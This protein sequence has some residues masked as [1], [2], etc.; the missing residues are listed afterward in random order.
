MLTSSL[1]LSLSFHYRPT[2]GLDPN[3][4]RFVWDYILEIKEKRIIILTTHSMEE[5]DALC[6]RIGI[7]VNGE[8]KSLGTPQEL[9]HMYGGGYRVIV[10]LQEGFAA[11]GPGALLQ[12]LKDEYDIESDEGSAASASGRAKTVA[13]TPR[14]L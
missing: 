5:A 13:G 4:R 14:R 9:K 7:M 11:D 12:V 3:T 6:T 10:R 1:S 8:L 2:T